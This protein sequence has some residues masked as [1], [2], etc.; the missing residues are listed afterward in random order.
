VQHRLN[1]GRRVRD[2]AQ[3]LGG[4]GLL[5]QR[6]DKVLPH[7]GDLASACF[8][9]LFEIGAGRVSSTDAGFRV[10]SGQTNLATVRSALRPFARQGH[11]IGTG[12]G[13][14][15]WLS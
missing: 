1:L 6:L 7:V 14:Q 8:E 10:R 12:I 9:L 3:N 15:R 13:P 4:G 11:L 5:L 2:D